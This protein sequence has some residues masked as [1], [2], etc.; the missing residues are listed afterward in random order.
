MPRA[1]AAGG[2]L[3]K[4][5]PILFS[6]A[7]V[8]AILDGR[9]TQTRRVVKL[10]E[11]VS[12][13]YGFDHSTGHIFC[14]NDYL[15]PDCQVVPPHYEPLDPRDL[16][17]P[18]GEPGDRL[19]VRETFGLVTGN[20]VRVVYRADAEQPP[21]IGYPDDPITDMKW[22]PSIYMR[23]QHSRITLEVTGIRVERLREI[24][25]D[26]CAWSDNPWVWVVEFRR[27]P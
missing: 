26:G 8:R 27:V 24:T 1:V 6:G 17:C 7:M 20:G 18:Y 14:H 15:P 12:N 22:T 25:E 2:G 3:V 11:T 9:K 16:P 23:R 13:G 10:P 19:W 4:E 21:R 5:R